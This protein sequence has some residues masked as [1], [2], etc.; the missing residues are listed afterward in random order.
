[1]L[2]CVPLVF[3]SIIKRLKSALEQ[4]GAGGLA[5]VDVLLDLVARVGLHQHLRPA[6]VVSPA[7]LRSE[8]ASALLRIALSHVVVQVRFVALVGL[9]GSCFR[10]S[11][12]T[13][14]TLFAFGIGAMRK[15][16]HLV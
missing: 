12:Q 15:S 2:R 13:A 6:E 10:Q 8:V 3:R 11:P 1:M 7:L 14:P 16:R 4:I 5:G 9:L